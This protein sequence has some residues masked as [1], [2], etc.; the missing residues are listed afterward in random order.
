LRKKIF[1]GFVERRQ[2]FCWFQNVHFISGLIFGQFLILGNVTNVFTWLWL[3]PAPF[4][5]GLVSDGLSSMVVML[6]VRLLALLEDS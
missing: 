1:I 6:V 2:K 3:C 5:L 4:C